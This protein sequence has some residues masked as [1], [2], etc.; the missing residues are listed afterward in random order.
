MPVV[1]FEGFN[2]KRPVVAFETIGCRDLIKHE[3][4]GILVP[5]YDEQKMK[6]EIL[7]LLR[8]T[9]KGEKLSEKAYQVLKTNYSLDRMAE[10]TKSFYIKYLA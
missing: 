4:T 6:E 9:A 1:I 2:S 5:A 7:D 10:E 3:E 8:N